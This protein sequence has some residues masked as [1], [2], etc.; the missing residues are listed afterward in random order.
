MEVS[1]KFDVSHIKRLYPNAVVKRNRIPFLSG[2]FVSVSGF[3]LRSHGDD[4]DLGHIHDGSSAAVKNP[5]RLAFSRANLRSL[6]ASTMV[7]LLWASSVYLTFVWMPVYMTDLIDSPVPNAFAVNSASMGVGIILAF[8]LA[9]WLSDKMSRKKVMGIGGVLICVLYPIMISII[10]EGVASRAFF[11]QM[12]L[13]VCLSCWGAP[14]M[15]WL[16]ESFDPS[17][18]LTSVSIGYNMAQALGGGLAPAIATEMVDN[19]GPDSPGYYISIIAL[20]ALVGLYS[21]APGKPSHFV[22]E[23]DYSQTDLEGGEQSYRD[24]EAELV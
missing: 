12:I 20:I 7:P 22:N 17:A 10:G 9:G 24:G 23:D 21:V 14:M 5:I 16:A 3:Y 2:I 18:R 13:G 11:A 6:L 15:A 4:D 1:E 8:P 19:W